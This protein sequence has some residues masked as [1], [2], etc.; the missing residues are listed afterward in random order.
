MLVRLAFAVMIQVDAE[1]L[2]IDE[3]LA[4]GDA[5]FQQKCFD[6]FERDPRRAARP[7]CSSRTTWAR[8]SASA[9]A[10]CCSST[11]DIVAIGEPERVGNR[12]LELNFSATRARADAEAAGDARPGEHERPRRRAFGDGAPSS[13][14]RGS[15]TPTGDARRRCCAAGERCDA[16]ACACAFNEDRHRTRVFAV[17]LQNEPAARPLVRC[18]STWRHE[19]TGTFARR[20][21]ASSSRVRSTTSLG[22]DRYTLDARPSPATAAR[23][24][25]AARAHDVGHRAPAPTP[26]AGSSTSR[27]HQVAI[28]RQPDGRRAPGVAPMTPPTAVDLGPPIK[29]PTRARRRPAPPAG[30]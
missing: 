25:A 28:E 9:T 29:G 15:R 10:R 26:P 8:S 13:R 2:L 3:V 30:A 6:E 14:T 17:T 27:T 23:V 22:A 18:A 1:I 24:L 21:G 12:Y 19:P 7:S 11:A 4:V 5:A 16:R 20:R